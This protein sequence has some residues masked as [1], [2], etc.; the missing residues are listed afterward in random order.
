MHL[1]RRRLLIATLVLTTAASAGSAVAQESGATGSR[2]AAEDP[3][4]ASQAPSGSDEPKPMSLEDGKTSQQKAMPSLIQKLPDY[5]GDIWNR[6]YLTG[7]WGGARKELAE[8][9]IL[10]EADVT[11]YLQGNAAGGKNTSKAFEYGGSA[12]YWLKLDTARM[13]LWP[14]GL[15][16]LHGETQIGRSV[17]RD[18]GS[19]MSPNYKM[20][21]PV[22][23]DPGVTT[24]SEWYMMQALS[25]K[26]VLVAGKLDLTAIA[27]RNEFAGDAKHTTQFMNTA[28]NINP[29]VFNGGPYTTLAAGVILIPTDWLQVAT[30][31][32]QNN[33]DAAATVSGFDSVFSEGNQTSVAQEYDFTIKPFDKV[34]HQRFGW[35][36]TNRDFSV[37]ETDSRVSLPLRP[38]TPGGE[39]SRPDNYCFYYNFDQYLFSEAE[40]P[41]Q[42]WGIFGRFGVAPQTGNA[43]QQF[44]SCGFGGKGTI[45]TRDRDTWGAGYYYAN[46][47][48]PLGSALGISR[49]QGV[50]LFYNIEVTPWLHVSP[51]LQVIIDP[52]G[53]FG[54]RDTALVYGI[55]GQIS[56]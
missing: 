3:P 44:Y 20:L 15:I 41:T 27:D 7:D 33:P 34:G 19:L 2:A 36:Y 5:T 17:N 14:G 42:G 37:F 21:L 35:L 40:D 39:K 32:L 10:F 29:V 53:G 23:G 6:S 4:T 11:Q 16:V 30:I 52:A 25:E 28:F 22:P 12:D 45:P 26:V 48:S 9:G 18:T 13:G 56:L 24:L 51:D 46:M 49:E 54:G 43:F 8:H 38:F 31:V 50:E 47:D 1:P 55:R